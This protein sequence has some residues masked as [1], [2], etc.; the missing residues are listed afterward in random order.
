MQWIWSGNVTVQCTWTKRFTVWPHNWGLPVYNTLYVQ[1]VGPTSVSYPVTTL[2]KYLIWSP[3]I[4]LKRCQ[5]FLLYRLFSNFTLMPIRWKSSFQ[6]W[7]KMNCYIIQHKLSF[8]QIFE[9]FDHGRFSFMH[10]TTHFHSLWV[11]YFLDSVKWW[12][13]YHGDTRCEWNSVPSTS[14]KHTNSKRYS[15][16]SCNIQA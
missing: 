6:T 2:R 3:Q 13:G 9:R 4:Q 16:R 5:F 11:V 10:Q 14:R 1:H 12:P 8:S 7:L 15:R